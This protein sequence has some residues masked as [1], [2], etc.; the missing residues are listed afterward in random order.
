MKLKSVIPRFAF[1][2]MQTLTP[3][4]GLG[5]IPSTDATGVPFTK[6]VNFALW[7]GAKVY[8]IAFIWEWSF[9]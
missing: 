6:R 5:F 8:G 7:C 3:S 2:S 1:I 4:Y 9:E